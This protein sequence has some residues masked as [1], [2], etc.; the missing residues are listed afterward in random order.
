MGS[1]IQPEGDKI[2]VKAATF[3]LTTKNLF[4][5]RI[6]HRPDLDSLLLGTFFDAKYGATHAD[7][8]AR[9][10]APFADGLDRFRFP[11][12]AEV[13][14]AFLIL[15]YR[16]W[17]GSPNSILS[18]QAF[19]K[20]RGKF[21]SFYDPYFTN[22]NP[23]DF[24]DFSKP[25]VLIGDTV[26]ATSD[27]SQIIR[28]RLSDDFTKRLFDISKNFGTQAEFFDLFNGM[29]ITSRLGD[30]TMLHLRTV[31]MA[32]FYHYETQV[33]GIDTTFSNSVNYVVNKVVINR[34]THPDR[35]EVRRR[36]NEN[37]HINHVSSPANVFTQVSIPLRDMVIQMQDLI[38][39]K[40][41]VVNSAVVRVEAIG[42]DDNIYSVPVPNN[43][44]LM[45]ESE[46]DN[47]FKQERLPNDSI[48]FANFNRVDSTYAF[49]I[50]SY[51]DREIRRV[52]QSDG[53]LNTDDLAETMEMVLVPVRITT[54]AGFGGGTTISSVRQQTLM[55]GVTIRSGNDP[56]RPMTISL[57]Y[58]GF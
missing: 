10:E 41:L 57:L 38:G 25:N 14:S 7:I 39:D 6:H 42:T 19:E 1:S 20:N 43:M 26:L 48:V 49:N 51:I 24:V 55:S 12:G 8:L 47:F 36:L 46:M 54:T 30:A 58:S 16:T 53:T 5:D 40:R 18:I 9:F 28:I 56:D 15:S 27:P 50:A 21:L 37:N 11:E 22:A 17:F 32:L 31:N 33:A 13:D 29:Y 23:N 44:L 34:F 2:T 4:I 45:P 52:R 35:D 3:P